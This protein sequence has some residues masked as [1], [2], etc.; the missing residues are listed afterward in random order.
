M[1]NLILN[2]IT[3]CL[4]F[5]FSFGLSFYEEFDGKKVKQKVIKLR[6]MII[7][8]KV[9]LICILYKCYVLHTKHIKTV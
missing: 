7:E 3:F 9:G 4:T 2:L 8:R 6:L 5:S 1:F